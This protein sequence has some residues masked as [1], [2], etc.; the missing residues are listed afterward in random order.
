[1][2]TKPFPWKCAHCREREVYP[3]VI[4]YATTIE[5]DGRSYDIDIPDLETPQCKLCDRLVIVD[6]ANRRVTQEFRKKA[7]LLSPDQIRSC[8]EA[9]GLTQQQLAEHLEIAESTVCRWE[10]G[11]QVQQRSLNK[12][13]CAFF[14]S[15]I[16][17]AFLMSNTNAY[18]GL[19]TMLRGREVERETIQ[20]DNTAGTAI[21]PFPSPIERSSAKSN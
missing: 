14:F 21:L 12:L 19:P 11:V 15:P 3:A 8:R 7:G 18:P 2:Q 9:L 17:R 5:H 1:V 13:L 6:E 4:D 16:S 20:A 10:T